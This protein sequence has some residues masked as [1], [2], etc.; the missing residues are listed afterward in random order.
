[1]GITG[2]LQLK[3]I[4]NLLKTIDAR[5]IIL[6]CHN[7]ADPDTLLSAYALK[8]L[9]V[10]IMPKIKVEIARPLGLN[11]LS[12]KILRKSPVKFAT[13]PNIEKSD[14]VVFLDI[15]NIMQIKGYAEEI[16]TSSKPI[17]I[18]DHHAEHPETKKTSTLQIRNEKA[19]STCEMVY[20]L[21]KEASIKPK[22]NFA[23]ALFIGI[24]YDTR[25]F[26][27]ATSN[28]FKI[29]AELIELG[30][31]AEKAL[32]LLEISLD[33]SERIA[34]L[35]AASRLRIERV[36]NW[37]IAL[38]KVSS[39]Q[40]SSARSLVRLGA[41]VA[42]VVGCRK[43]KLLVNIRSSREFFLKTNIHLGKDIAIPLGKRIGGMGGGHS[44]SAG[45][46]GK[47]DIEYVLEACLELI[48]EKLASYPNAS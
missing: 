39:F 1:M 34:R 48:L 15:N 6:F 38:S 28:T 35:K 12:K 20:G 21:F 17:I 31:N 46:N 27:L 37:I 8:E 44:T 10:T 42:V 16:E 36:E 3:N 29:V 41:H 45:A 4:L 25:H 19:S 5:S 22:T 40:A 9:I 43:K 30:V 47:A 26:V 14:A 32:S 11:K 23:E 24:A 18:I 7:N 2:Q 13:S 33:P